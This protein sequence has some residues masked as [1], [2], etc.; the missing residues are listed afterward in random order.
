MSRSDLTIMRLIDAGCPEPIT[1]HLFLRRVVTP[2][3]ILDLRD[4]EER[5]DDD[6]VDLVAGMRL[7]ALVRYIGAT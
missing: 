6:L 4:I 1:V 3:G 7:I 2:Y 5:D